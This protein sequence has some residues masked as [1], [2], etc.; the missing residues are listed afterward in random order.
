M[1]QFIDIIEA[2]RSAEFTGCYI[3][4]SG[5]VHD[6]D[7][8]SNLH[9]ADIAMDHFHQ[10][11]D[12]DGWDMEDNDWD[13]PEEKPRADPFGGFGIS[14]RKIAEANRDA[15]MASAMDAGWM[16]V[17]CIRDELSNYL[18][19][20]WM[21]RATGQQ[22]RKLNQY[23]DRVMAHGFE[24][25]SYDHAGEYQSF[26]DLADFLAALKRELRRD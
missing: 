23:L 18:A 12:D 11:E 22:V 14:S 17:T 4:P 15:A 24:S 3:E 10:D 26:T 21:D 16:Q 20:T 2:V 9:H 5:V 19:I 7:H 8:H 25:M 13:D 1:R 6:C